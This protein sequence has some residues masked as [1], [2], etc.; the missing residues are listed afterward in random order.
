MRPLHEHRRVL[1]L[2]ASGLNDC[3][4]SRL[5]GI[6]RPTIRDWRTGKVRSQ[7]ER[8]SKA[9][10]C[11][12]CDGRPLDEPAYAYLLGLYLGDGCLSLAPRGVYRLRIFLDLKYPGIID[13]CAN[14]MTIVRGRASRTGRSM[15]VGCLEVY[16]WKHWK[17]LFPQHGAGPKHKRPI[18]LE[19]W[20]ERIVTKHAVFLVRGLIHS[21]GCRTL[22][23]VNGKAYPRY[24]FT[25]NSDD[26][27][28]IFGKACRQL[29]I[30][31]RQSN[32][33][34]ISIARAKDVAALD[35]FIG[36]KR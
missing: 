7:G 6:P 24:F 8:H 10:P 23:R 2:V 29:G 17:C 14:S 15:K 33:K 16:H 26:I 1:E 13:A 36:A 32:W 4:I 35:Q 34:T 5:T 21:D 9:S 20:Q 31:W 18:R 3:Q 12:I 28:A 22:N 27:R 25:N 19:P 30:A 11:P